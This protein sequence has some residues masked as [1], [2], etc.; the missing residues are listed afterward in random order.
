VDWP[1]SS[2]LLVEPIVPNAEK[3]GLTE[4]ECS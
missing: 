4:A 1:Q 2:E 3:I